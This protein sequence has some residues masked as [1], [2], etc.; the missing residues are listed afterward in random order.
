ML[1]QLLSC[2]KAI[3]NYCRYFSRYLKRL[4]AHFCLLPV[5]YVTGISG[6][7]TAAA[8]AEKEG[9]EKASLFLEAKYRYFKPASIRFLI[10]LYQYRMALT[11]R[12]ISFPDNDYI[13]HFCV[14]G[15]RYTHRAIQFLLSSLL[16]VDNIPLI[17]KN[18]AITILIHCNDTSKEA[19]QA[20]SAAKALQKYAAIKFVMIPKSIL[21]SL[22]QCQ[23]Y[24]ARFR[25]FRNLN[26][27][28]QD[29]KFAV[30][31]LLQ[32]HALELA[33]KNNSFI[34]FFMPDFLLANGMLKKAFEKIQERT[35]VVS[36]MYRTPFKETED[37][38]ENYRASNASLSISS[39]AL[40][41]FKIQN[42]HQYTKFQVVAEDTG[43]FF[44]CAQMIFKDKYGYII[45][46]MHYHPILVDCAKINPTINIG[47]STID[48]CFF[49]DN[50]ITEEKVRYEEKV[51]VCSDSNEMAI[52]EISDPITTYATEAYGRKGDLITY[53]KE[54][55]MSHVAYMLNSSADAFD[56]PLHRYFV[57]YRHKVT[58][59]DIWFTEDYI[60]DVQ[61]IDNVYK[62]V[63][64]QKVT[65]AGEV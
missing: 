57:S 63:D 27:S 26:L 9:V 50:D 1:K 34:S 6:R 45:R 60:D 19:V 47:C 18:Y 61:F 29:M 58:S 22:Q 30:L 32:T 53:K 41:K 62:T 10:A 35:A 12:M 13:I 5:Y 64:D 17:S 51:W 15:E 59:D 7:S 56:R 38:M 2:F 28:N 3:V 52:I 14:W 21:T 25:F 48:T 55:L 39:S 54:L 23:S 8:I 11:K 31:G 44:P 24:P 42:M 40:T 43:N 4:V 37:F 16:A 65:K 20:S 36:T 49:L 33:I 46:A